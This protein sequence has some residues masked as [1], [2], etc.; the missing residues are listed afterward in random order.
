M[1][2]NSSSFINRMNSVE[3]EEIQEN[4]YS[5]LNDCKKRI[6]CTQEELSKTI[7]NKITELI[8]LYIKIFKINL[9][10]DENGYEEICDGF[11]SIITKKLFNYIF[12]T[13]KQDIINDY[14]ID[15]KI[16]QFS[17]IK[18]E[19]LEIKNEIINDIYIDTAINSK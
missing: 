18:P 7:Q 9:E 3:A 17:F 14:N 19:H 13:N 10:E 12:S 16:K 1:E 8:E 5:F 2:K 4:L 15:L 11:E 6:N